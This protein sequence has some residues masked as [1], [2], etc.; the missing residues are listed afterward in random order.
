MGCYVQ[1]YPTAPRS[2][3]PHRGVVEPGLA[4]F[5]PSRPQ[6]YVTVRGQPPLVSAGARSLGPEAPAHVDHDHGIY[7]AATGQ[8]K[9]AVPP[10]SRCPDPKPATTVDVPGDGESRRRAILEGLRVDREQTSRRGAK[11]AL[12]R[13]SGNAEWLP[14][15][16][17]HSTPATQCRR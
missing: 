12:M 2:A 9:A 6:Y 16:S 14:G 15:S 8:A 7:D 11:G 13:R 4:L 1:L 10:E 5:Q 3:R 17:R